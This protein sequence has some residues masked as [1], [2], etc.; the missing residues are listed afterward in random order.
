MYSNA[1]KGFDDNIFVQKNFKFFQKVSS[2]WDLS[3]QPSHVLIMD[4]D[5]SHVILQAIKQAQ[6][7]GLDMVTLPSHTS[8]AL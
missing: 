8:H 5:G 1:R 6:Q 4:G 3:N 2:W 7:F